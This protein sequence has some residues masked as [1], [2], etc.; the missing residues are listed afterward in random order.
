[1]YRTIEHIGL[2]RACS[3]NVLILRRYECYVYLSYIYRIYFVY[4]P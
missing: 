2:T 1:M 3:T 4:N